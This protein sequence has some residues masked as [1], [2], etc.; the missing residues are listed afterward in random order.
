MEKFIA[1]QPIFN[2]EKVVYGYELLFRSGPQNYFDGS[3]PEAAAASSIDN[4]LLFGIDRL[5]QGRRAFINCTRDFLLRDFP[6][7]L[8]ANSVV[9]EI[10]ESIEPDDEIVA[11]CRRLRNA[12]Y[13]I[14][15]DDFQESPAWLPLTELAAFIKVDVLLSP[16]PEQLRLAKAFAKKD[17]R[18]VAEKV[19]THEDFQRTLGWGY[20]YFQGYFFSRPEML[21]RHDIPSNKLNYLLVLQAVNRPDMDVHE[22]SERI[23]AEAS[24]SYRLLRYLNS[25]AFPLIAQVKSIPHAL[26]LLGE[27]GVRRWVSVVAIACMGD[28]KPAELI[29]L[30]LIRAH[31]CESLASLAS[32]GEISNDLFLLGLLS[33]IDAVLDMQMR[34]VLA[35]ITISEE[36]RGALLGEKNK[37]R[38]LFDLALKYEMGCWDALAADA[39]R[40]RVPEAAIPEIYIQSVEWAKN[41]LSGVY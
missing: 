9:L 19:E 36:I 33:A 31:F 27:R 35:E 41:L 6:A 17:V 11:A 28:Q 14:A 16:Q 30:P 8:P 2:S 32:L 13:L 26:S 34:D 3:H 7:T 15:L 1:R 40:L 20:S 22:V 38:E 23:K 4:L 12:G 18:L 29:M 21:T 24:L 5:T 25:P 10:L 39:K 37:L